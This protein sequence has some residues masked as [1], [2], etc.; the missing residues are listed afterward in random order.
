M[1]LIPNGFRAIVVA[2][3]LLDGSSQAGLHLPGGVPWPGGMIYYAFDGALSVAQ[4]QAYLDGL[5]EYE[6]AA[7]VQFVARTIQ[8]PYIL[9]KYSP[10]G[11]NLYSVGDPHTVEINLL[12]R[13]QICHEMGHAFGLEHEHQ[14]ANRDD[15]IT[16]NYGNIALEDQ[17]AFN[18]LP[19]GVPF[20]G[21]DFES[22]MHYGRNVYALNPGVDTIQTKPGF[23]KYQR[24]LSN[25][26]LSPTD[27]AHMASLYGAPLV[28][29]SPVVTTTSDAGIGS[30][31]AAIY[32]AQDHPG[33]T[34]TFN[35]PT[36]DPGHVGGI[37]TIKPTGSL[38]PLATNGITI[39]A[40][41]Q[42]GYAG[43]PVVFLNGS[44]LLPEA[45]ELPGLLFLEA[46]CTVRGLGVQRFPWSGI[47][48]RYSDATGNRVTGCSVG[49]DSAGTSAAPNAFQGI[50]ISDGAHGN[51]IGGSGPNERNVVSGN[52]RYGV[53]LSGSGTNDNSIIGNLI[54]TNLE[55][56]A[57]LPNPLSGVIL[58]E[59][60]SGN[61]IGPGNVISG[62]T[63]YGVWVS[64][65]ATTGNKVIGNLIGL[66]HAGDAALP[67]QTSGL[68]LT[69][70]ANLNTVGGDSASSRNVISGNTNA[71]V[72][73][74]GTGTSGNRVLGNFIGT[75]ASGDSAVPNS[76]AGVYLIGGC[77][78]NYLG[79]GPGTGNLIS[80]NA[81]VGVLVAD[82]GT[83]GNF[84][85]NN[86][87]GPS[88]AGA[89]F[90]NQFDGVWLTNGSLAN[91]IGGT[92]PGAANI[93]EGNPH[94]GIVLFDAPTAGQSF[95]RNS[96]FGNGWQGIALYDGS[97]H[98][99]AA[100]VISSAA[101][102]IG[103]TV[104][105]TLTGVTPGSYV[106]EFFASPD[107]KVFVGE[108]MV[109]ADG[110]GS[111]TISA[112][113]PAIV[114]A[115]REITATATS[116]STG[117]TSELSTAVTVNSV[118]GDNDGLPDAYESVTAG[119][120]SSNSS[121]AALDND[122]DGFTN[123]QEFVAGTNPNHSGSR[124]VG[125]GAVSGGEFQLSFNTVVGKYYR[126]ERS[127]S[128]SGTWENAAVNVE[129]TGGV[130]QVPMPV[131]W[132]SGRQFFRVV[133]GE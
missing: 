87:I 3:A 128:P 118:D 21:Y 46:N 108:S 129:G 24:R 31:R 74:T 88:A 52:A 130:L 117:D 120:S 114:A 50:Q 122:G 29:L 101:L 57:A 79:D 28:P 23:E 5:R 81:T 9:F 132:S 115:G 47:V 83:T 62:N 89:H 19:T 41:T 85:R 71:G 95:R 125:T 77:S 66:N 109:T 92:A 131:A 2:V 94:R 1:K 25:A 44:A 111:A 80:G 70:Q 36:S 110:S 126:I 30:L 33:A 63:E 69:G 54:G 34:I 56:N 124:L 78:G 119:L 73:L 68:I 67:N 45:G 61:T 112:V 91:T 100:P 26:A 127:A 60:A 105:G 84:V 43:K 12:T 104:T 58:S 96:I 32:Y 113:L 90:T 82:P 11:P 121:D 64:G 15:F 37:F 35:I 93:I 103:T 49:L 123:L 97:N 51:I 72:Y 55:G 20:G 99:Q 98:S 39:D 8:T 106:I 17:G 16:V 18:I 14:R 133:A 76:F 59:G 22:V 102:G 42:P 116:L 6:L 65:V 38:P 40:T 86:R 48:M 10:T 53:F 7:N 75:S 13:G 107:A 27:R 4:Q